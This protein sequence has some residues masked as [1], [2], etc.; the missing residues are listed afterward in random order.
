MPQRFRG[1]ARGRQVRLSCG[2]S[3]DQSQSWR[4]ITYRGEKVKK[5]SVGEYQTAV[6]SDCTVNSEGEQSS[7]HYSK[8]PALL[9]GPLKPRAQYI[10]R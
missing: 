2:G 4:Y 3:L 10:L 7:S 6:W 1:D 9:R 8:F 5:N